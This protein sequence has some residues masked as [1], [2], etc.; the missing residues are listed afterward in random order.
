MLILNNLALKG[1]AASRFSR[2]VNEVQVDKS[3]TEI[4]EY[5]P[6]WYYS[7]LTTHYSLLTTTYYLLLRFLRKALVFISAHSWLKKYKKIHVYTWRQMQTD[8][9][10]EGMLGVPIEADAR[11]VRPYRSSGF[12]HVNE[13]P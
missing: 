11:A 7:L 1:E 4:N 12:P 3:V 8:L 6:A 10:I 13:T 5:S 2:R 9:A